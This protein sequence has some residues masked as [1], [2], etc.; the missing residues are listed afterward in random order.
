[1]SANPA[2]SVFFA[3]SPMKSRSF[4]SPS[5]LAT[6]LADHFLAHTLPQEL[7]HEF[8]LFFGQAVEDFH[9]TWGQ[10]LD[11]D[12]HSVCRIVGKDNS[13]T[14]FL[15]LGYLAFAERT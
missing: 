14:D 2:Y 8:R 5:L 12:Q 4:C 15:G 9:L 13:F 10:Q 6:S 1:M 7:P 11:A 3:R